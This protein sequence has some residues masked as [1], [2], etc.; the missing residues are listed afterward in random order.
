MESDLGN[1]FTTNLHGGAP[2]G[3]DGG[4]SDGNLHGGGDPR[5]NSSSLDDASALFSLFLTN[6]TVASD[7]VYANMLRENLRGDIY[8]IEVNVMHIQQFSEKLFIMV[9]SSP[10]RTLPRLEYAA[11]QVADERRLFSAF[12]GGR[13]DVQ[14][15][16][17]WAVVPLSIR[18]LA[19][20][21]VAKLVCISGIV[22]KCSATHARCVRAAIQ[23]TSCRS[24]TFIN[25]GK[26]IDLPPQCQDNLARAGGGG[27]P[28]GAAGGKC[29]PNPYVL[30]PTECEYEDQQVLKLQELPEE[31]PTGELPRHVTVIVD[32]Y[33]VDKANPGTR[34]QL[35][36]IVSVQEKRGGGETSGKQQSKGLKATAGLRAQYIRSCGLMNL[37]QKS[38]GVSVV[39]I[40]QNFSSR[41]RSRTTSAWQ[42]GDEAAFKAFAKSGRVYQKM[43]ECI[44]PAIYGLHDQKKAIV[45]LL[46]GGTRK[47]QGESNAHLRGDLNVLLI[48]DPSTAKSQL[49]K[50]TEKVAPIA[51]YTSGK[52]SSAA[53]L[54]ASV[55]SS[56]GGDFYL[57]AGSLVLADGG[58]V[59]I[60]EFDKMRDQDQVAI[61]EAMEQQT[62]SIAKAN[63]TTMLNSRTSV[64]AAANPTLGSY[65]PLQSNE[66][67]M[68]FQG[69]ILSRFDLIFKVLDPRNPEMDHRLAQ[70]VVNLH[71]GG[72]QKDHGAAKAPVERNFMTKYIAYA[73]AMCRPVISQEAQAALLDFF[74]QVRRDSYKHTLDA[75]RSNSNAKAPVIQIT[76]RQLESMVRISES[77][78][79]MRLDPVATAS[80]AA[81]AI[82]LFQV[83]TVDAINSGVVDNNMTEVQSE[84]VLKIEEAVRRRVAVGSTVEYPRLVAELLKMAF[85]SRLVDR[86]IYIMIR[87]DELEWRKQR[88][89]VHRL[90]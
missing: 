53:G 51:I 30:L 29:R 80:D 27:G 60:D 52:G 22:V 15:Q 12:N 89:Q 41:V 69:S 45:C 79:K 59:C 90:R 47:K 71:K 33:L 63:L 36:G 2:Q 75:M 19:Q 5:L 14:V 25:G 7:C 78:A 37:S 87:R 13:R 85:E 20:A 83:A 8:F 31:V 68:D 72:S 73:K 42:P 11:A 67:Q 21:Q 43:S 40:H 76:A 56:G 26:S 10:S 44:D 49:L 28:G 50:F 17:Y 4:L 39:S 3:G 65:D 58:V 62:I 48:G 16:L 70:H 32:R 23:C 46:F 61:H 82:R 74:V 66:D 55:V 38:D 77:L 81:E 9:Q 1:V 57:E 24:K 86:A 6:F 35:V 18:Q 88:S 34:I 84:Q 64:L 54:T